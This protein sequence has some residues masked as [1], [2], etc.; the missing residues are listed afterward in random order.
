MGIYDRDYMRN[1]DRDRSETS[2]RPPSGGAGGSWLS[3]ALL[4]AAIIAGVL[5]L[6]KVVVPR[7]Q[8]A[9]IE[10]QRMEHQEEFEREIMRSAPEVEFGAP[11]GLKRLVNINTATRDELTTVPYITDP[12]AR[13][14]MAHRPYA[15]FD[16]LCQIPGIKEKK[17]QLI[18]PYIE[19]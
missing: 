3:G 5:L 8:E 6:G 13:S 19:K 11:S 18:M 10:R 4:A 9:A 17:L 15:E 2:A 12:I 1:R 7:W 16:E 14:I